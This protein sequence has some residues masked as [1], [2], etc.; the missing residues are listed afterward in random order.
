MNIAVDL[1]P[2][3]QALRLAEIE[4][5]EI[6][7][8]TAEA[9]R[10]KAAGRPVIVLGTGEPDFDTPDNIKEAAIAAIRAGDT[11][12][13]ALDGTPALKAAIARRTSTATG[14]EVTP[15]MVTVSTGAKQVIFNAMMATVNPGDEVIVA[16]PYWTSYSDIIRIAGATP[17]EVPCHGANG[18]LLRADALKAALSERTAWL[19]L[20][21]P[22]NPSGASY[23]AE[24]LGAILD[25][26]ADHPRCWLLFDEIYEHIAYGGAHVNP[27]ALKHAMAART[28]LVNGVSKA[29][30]MTGWR[31]G[32]GIGDPR[33]I[34]AMAV[35]QSQSTSCPS[36]VSQAAALE[37]LSG[38]QE[39]LQSRRDSF[40]DR[41]DFCLQALKSIEGIDCIAPDGA[42]YLF[43]SC[44]G[45][46]GRRTPQGDV[47]TD[48]RHFA[49]WL[50]DEV[51]VAV[52]PGSAFGLSP[53]FRISYAT[54]MEELREAMSRIQNACAR[55]TA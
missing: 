33:L 37:A 25:V 55:L 38:T 53:Y 49:R 28:L 45:L 2:F 10:R 1:P 42:F 14:A 54:S 41:R 5:S 18:F 32:Y 36:S 19:F 35:V 30:A 52:I 23:D 8:I 6:L 22:S 39:F 46:I 11:K 16:T 29:Y 13:T 43:A 17:I 50:L 21:A 44:A 48:D 51:D 34:K 7:A 12:Y 27:Y 24:S 26:L 9:G 20:N 3:R 4:V 15:S 47:L 40:R 31:I